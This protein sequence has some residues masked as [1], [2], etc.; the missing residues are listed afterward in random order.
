MQ[1]PASYPGRPLPRHEVRISIQID[2]SDDP[3]L[4]D[5]LLGASSRVAA[6][7]SLPSLGFRTMRSSSP[8]LSRSH[9]RAPSSAAAAA[10]AQGAGVQGWRSL[11]AA[12]VAQIQREGWRKGLF[13]K[14]RLRSGDGAGSTLQNGLKA[15][16]SLWVTEGD[17]PPPAAH[18][19]ADGD[20]PPSA[21]SSGKSGRLALSRLSIV[22][23]ALLFLL[24][25]REVFF[26]P[27]STSAKKRL[28]AG[29]VSRR[30]PFASLRAVAPPPS[31][32]V[33]SLPGYDR[34]WKEEPHA[35]SAE[36]YD[37]LPSEEG[38][39]TAIV[40]HW[41][42]TDNVKV[43]LAHLCQY[44]FLDAV[45][46]WN[47][48]PDITL[49]RE[50]FATSLCPA[51]KLRIYN[52]PRNLYFFARYLA[53][54]THSLTDYC[55]FQDDDWVVQPLRAMYSQFKRDPEGPV[56]VSTNSEV[57]T[58][59]GL[60]WCFFN[61][62]L[63]TCFSW[64]GTGAFTSRTHVERF[65]A[66]TTYLGY[67]R[68]ELAHADNSFTSFM[69]EPPYVIES[70]LA[71][72]PD[73]G[74]HSER[75][76]RQRNKEFIQSG[77]V[78]L[79]HFLHADYPTSASLPPVPVLTDTSPYRTS[80]SPPLP[81]HPYAHH[82][83]APCLSTPRSSSS[84]SSALLAG[85]A[86]PQCLFITNVPLL[87]P[88]DAVPYPGPEAVGSL[89]RWEEHLGYTARGWKEG[90]EVWAE[91][92]SWK[93][94][95]SYQG[96]VDGDPR[97]AFRS[98]DVAQEHD[99]I[100]LGL[101]APIDAAWIPKLVLHVIL[102]D[103]AE[104]LNAAMIEVS[105]DGYRWA[106]PRSLSSPSR[107][108]TFTCTPTRHFSTRPDVSFPSS[109]LLSS[110]ATRLRRADALLDES[111][112]SFA[113]WWRRRRRRAER[114]KECRVEL[115]SRF[116]GA[117]AHADDA[118]ADD[119]NSDRWHPAPEPEVEEDDEATSAVGWRFVRV[120]L[121]GDGSGRAPAV[122]VGWGVY[123]MWLTEGEKGK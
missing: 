27:S 8:T 51:H 90:G 16:A 86:D 68:D 42:R 5:K 108:S 36:D 38:D 13:G 7:P 39:T 54:A 73:A 89:Q 100:G 102:E 113:R 107:P 4:S 121:K 22:V 25:M 103:A 47:N 119:P 114:L 96:A 87:P 110:L 112:S 19:H 55:F 104:I 48:N 92:E 82:S 69:N 40:L 31:R 116:I 43:I 109:R 53:C 41:K 98:P 9:T 106:P 79:S 67:S 123:E 61:H 93:R 59:Y 111:S 75:E 64:V 65:L 50:T 21:S 84:S 74:G 30:N 49:T 56:V 2:K 81:P 45:L 28:T 120:V 76:G 18:L 77:L 97:T 23:I 35:G 46:V 83:R 57:A 105:V 15:F 71:Q 115:S 118:S 37:A 52:S 10:R 66:T 14:A 88:P 1:Q 85:L 20:L 24:G 117:L 32:Y 33:T 62:P 94:A 34:L 17:K 58:L 80:L 95:W 99:Y 63:H 72:L 122:R 12:Q 70:G 26:S 29:E 11:I 101:L 91:E 6:P 44:T 60:E 3:Q 78:R